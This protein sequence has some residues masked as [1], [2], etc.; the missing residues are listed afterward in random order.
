MLSCLGSRDLVGGVRQ[1]ASGAGDHGEG[2]GQ[3]H[4]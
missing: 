1:C 3:G 2:W 4:G